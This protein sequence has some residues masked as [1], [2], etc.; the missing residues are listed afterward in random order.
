MVGYEHG[1]QL[2]SSPHAVLMA[3][4]AVDQ[5]LYT[6]TMPRARRAFR[7]GHCSSL[8]PRPS[9]T[10]LAG[11][12]HC[13]RTSELHQHLLLCSLRGRGTEVAVT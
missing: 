3:V 1:L 13:S 5:C 7:L 9:R 11:M 6:L 4:G 10:S 2:N 12:L 8:P